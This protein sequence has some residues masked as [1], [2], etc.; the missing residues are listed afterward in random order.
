MKKL[1]DAMDVLGFNRGGK[2]FMVLWWTE[3]MGNASFVTQVLLPTLGKVSRR[4]P[5]M[6]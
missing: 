2:L 3:M 6:C 5:K 1:D 4:T